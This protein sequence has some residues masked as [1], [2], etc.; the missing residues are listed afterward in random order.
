VQE[1]AECLFTQR[2]QWVLD[3]GNMLTKK[4][5][6]V[7]LTLFF[8]I[9]F[10]SPVCRAEERPQVDP[11][12]KIT[13]ALDHLNQDGLCGSP[14][15]QRALHY[16]FCIPGDPTHAAQVRGIDPTIEIFPKSRGRISCGPGE[17]LCVG[18]TH[19]PGFKT[20]LVKLASLPYV[21]RIDQAFF[22]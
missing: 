19:Q 20:V 15:G 2:S 12:S 9:N 13:F 1:Q 16:E 21:K 10:L 17:Y 7:L 4:G 18:N 11:M 14:G 6:T 5:I 3:G 22:E 8:S